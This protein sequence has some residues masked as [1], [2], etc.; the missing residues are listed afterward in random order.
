MSKEN[1]LMKLCKVSASNFMKECASTQYEAQLKLNLPIKESGECGE[2]QTC[3]G[4]SY[5]I[6][7]RFKS[8][9][10]PLSRRDDHLP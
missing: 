1:K 4:I 6:S 5:V 7:M 9:Y 8:S 10:S 2:E 3:S